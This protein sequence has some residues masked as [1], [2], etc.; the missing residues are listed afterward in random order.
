MQTDASLVGCRRVHSPAAEI[1]V[2]G[3]ASAL[4]SAA[5]RAPD[6][7]SLPVL[8]AATALCVSS[9]SPKLSSTRPVSGRF[10]SFAGAATGAGADFAAPFSPSSSAPASTTFRLNFL[11]F[12]SADGHF[13]YYTRRCAMGLCEI[14]SHMNRC[15]CIVT[16]VS[17]LFYD[18]KSSNG[19]DGGPP[20]LRTPSR[21]IAHLEVAAE[22]CYSQGLLYSRAL[23]D[24]HKW[25]G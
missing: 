15:I 17:N 23:L 6:G 8:F 2:A 22:S 3:L 1:C 4:G 5:L 25:K 24:V 9:S 21:D 16:A 18:G 20:P 12:I 14:E 11:L 10:F 7:L 19:R 13:R